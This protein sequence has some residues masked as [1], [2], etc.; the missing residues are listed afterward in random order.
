M[1]DQSSLPINTA[2]ARIYLHN[3]LLQYGNCGEF[4]GSMANDCNAAGIYG[5]HP[6]QV[7]GLHGAQAVC[8]R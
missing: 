3:S 2:L 1:Q 8:R 5:L 7:P 4:D 6:A